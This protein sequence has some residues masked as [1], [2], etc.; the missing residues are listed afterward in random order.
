M[1]TIPT[2]ALLACN[3][4]ISLAILMPREHFILNEASS[5]ISNEE[6]VHALTILQGLK[7]GAKSG[8]LFILFLV[9]R[10]H[11]VAASHIHWRAFLVHFAEFSLEHLVLGC[12]SLKLILCHFFTANIFSSLGLVLENGTQMVAK[13]CHIST[14]Q[15]I[16]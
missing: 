16:D 5:I 8:V 9:S 11:L 1:A 3:E 7:K 14:W 4:A 12:R 15:A 13:A 10:I 6:T 2:F